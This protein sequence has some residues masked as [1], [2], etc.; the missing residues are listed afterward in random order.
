MHKALSFFPALKKINYKI[1]KSQIV[2]FTGFM[3][4]CGFGGFSHQDIV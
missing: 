1:N 4:I 2:R 3:L